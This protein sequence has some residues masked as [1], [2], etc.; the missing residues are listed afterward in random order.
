M[1]GARGEDSDTPHGCSVPMLPFGLARRRPT[2]T[3]PVLMAVAAALGGLGLV[4]QAGAQS[5]CK[6]SLTQ[7][8]HSC[9]NSCAG[10]C[11]TKTDNVKCPGASWG[12]TNSTYMNISCATP[13][14]LGREQY[15][16]IPVQE[17]LLSAPLACSG[18]VLKGLWPFDADEM[19]FPIETMFRDP[20]IPLQ[21]RP[22]TNKPP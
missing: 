3:L 18:V 12:N 17:A 1:V 7:V 21:G 4:G 11:S 2:A 15:P 5:L 14:P 10:R 16:T 22:R 13:S 6:G 8:C 19:T 9:P 20:E